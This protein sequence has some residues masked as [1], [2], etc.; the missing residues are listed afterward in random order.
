MHRKLASWETREW[1]LKRGKN[2]IQGVLLLVY[3]TLSWWLC[4]Y[5]YCERFHQLNT[6]WI[7]EAF[8]FLSDFSSH[9]YISFCPWNIECMRSLADSPCLML[10]PAKT[11]FLSS[12]R[13]CYS[14]RQKQVSLM[15]WAEN[16][17]DSQ[18][19]L[20]ADQMSLPWG[21]PYLLKVQGKAEGWGWQ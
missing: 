19:D 11:T 12:D 10:L 21:L 15:H 6:H 18:A 5:G 9:S 13:H 2:G 16:N 17:S 1:K 20:Q 3:N 7:K 8:H 4:N 14:P